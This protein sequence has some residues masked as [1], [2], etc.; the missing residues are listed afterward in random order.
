MKDYFQLQKVIIERFLKGWGLAPWLV[1]LLV[2]V[3]FVGGSLLLLERT[4]Y[5]AYLIA[6]LSLSAYNWFSGRKRNDFLQLNFGKPIFRKIRLLENGL[7]TLPFLLLFLF[8]G[9]W[10]LA[11]VQI[12]VGGAMTL[13]SGGG[14]TAFTL[15]TPFS[16][17]PW[18]FALGFRQYW[19]LWLIAVFLLVMG[20]RAENFELSAFSWFIT[21]FG[22]TAFYQKPEPGFYVWVHA[23]TGQQLLNRKLLF[24]G[25]HLL[26]LGLPF[27]IALLVSFP[28]HWMLIAGLQLLAILYLIMTITVKYT[29]Y[30]NEVDIVKAFIMGAGFM[31]PPLLLFIIPYF[32]QKAVRQLGLVLA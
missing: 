22:A 12:L 20:I 25:I 9:Y 10:A 6:V 14:F 21:V 31:L 23:M 28:E 29:A 17:H 3:F 15:P 8:K 26:I 19:W 5:A 18:E 11:L 32:Y 4:D 24:G 27:V 30:P 1:Y 2:P 16:K 13:R 7:V